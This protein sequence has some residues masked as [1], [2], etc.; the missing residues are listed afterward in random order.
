M[1]VVLDAIYLLVLL[2]LSPYLVYKAC[3]TGKYRRGI[4]SKF[5]GLLDRCDRPLPAHPE[6]PHPIVWFHGV[7]VGEIHLLG[8]IVQRFRERHPDWVCAISTTTDTGYDEAKKRFPGIS[9]FHWPLDFS[10]AT[11][12]VLATVRPT[13]VVLA[14]GEMWPNFLRMA[15]RQGAKVAVI[16]GRMSPRSFRRHCRFRR[17]TGKLLQYIDL[18]AVQTIA[19]AASFRALGVVQE[20]I[21]VTGSVKY[22]GVV[23]DRQNAKTKEMAKLFGIEKDDLVFVAGSTQDPE[24]EIAVAVWE[25]CRRDYPKL[26]L[27]LVPRQKD[28]FEAVAG[29]LAKQNKPFVRRSELK[30]S[31]QD[32]DSI[33]LVDSIGE[34]NAIWGLSHIAFVGGSVDGRRGGQNMI[35]P[36]AYGSA[37]MFGPHVW[38][39]RETATRLV[40]A[41]A[42]VQVSDAAAMED[43]SRRLLA[44]PA[45]RAQLGTRAQELVKSQQGATER[46]IACLESLI[47]PTKAHELAA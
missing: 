37:V 12:R 15:K 4:W 20:R 42:A 28:R 41:G 45:E 33:I 11:R 1:A 29:L 19:Y 9:V 40:E 32:R 3:T 21:A 24:E 23:M 46:T 30:K 13:L 39:F 16:N 25:A 27:I 44:N 6:A 34:L 18:F 35:E 26:R 14:E 2:L 8:P 10:W 38:N 17:F 22:D 7:S 5:T 36:A 47:Q 43:V 31:V